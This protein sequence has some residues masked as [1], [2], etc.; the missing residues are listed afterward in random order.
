M[1]VTVKS[2]QDD[3][4][5]LWLGFSFLLMALLIVV[6]DQTITDV[7]VPSIVTDLK[8]PATSATLVVT[9]YMVVGAAFMILMGKVVD[10]F[11][12][13][14]ILLWSMCVFALGSLVTGVAWN[15]TVL[16]IG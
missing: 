6:L 9:I 12:A 7:V 2:I 10:V 15:F 5:K 16:I 14:R 8:I 11:G 4:K 13:R 3:P 1:P